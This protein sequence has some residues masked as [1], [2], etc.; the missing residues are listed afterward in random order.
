MKAHGFVVLVSLTFLQVNGI[1]AEVKGQA[2]RALSHISV[3]QMDNCPTNLSRLDSQVELD[4]VT[5]SG[6][7]KDDLSPALLDDRFCMYPISTVPSE[8]LSY[9][10]NANKNV[11]FAKNVN[12]YYEVKARY[13][14]VFQ[15]YSSTGERAA[16]TRVF[17]NRLTKEFA[18]AP[19]LSKYYDGLAVRVLYKHSKSDNFSAEA[20]YLLGTDASELVKEFERQVL[21]VSGRAATPQIHIDVAYI[22]NGVK[23]E[24][25]FASINDRFVDNLKPSSN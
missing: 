2:E 7:S 20:L 16:L 25:T 9:T 24:N 19:S 15:Q 14:E 8:L 23:V 3:E 10:S 4:F 13:N 6:F 11:H 1:A 22:F 12:D 21:V 5:G 18:V 17:L